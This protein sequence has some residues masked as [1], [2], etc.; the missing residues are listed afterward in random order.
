MGWNQ[1]VGSGQVFFLSLIPN[2]P[3]Y[4][5]SLITRVGHKTERKTQI[6]REH[7]FQRGESI[8]KLKLPLVNR[9]PRPKTMPQNTI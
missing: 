2:C 3:T 5:S 7:R 6:N 9:P 1:P 8:G 4:F